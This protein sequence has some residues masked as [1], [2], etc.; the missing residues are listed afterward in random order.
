MYVPGIVVVTRK[1]QMEGLVARYGTRGQAKFMLAQAALHEAERNPQAKTR[2]GVSEALDFSVAQR[3]DEKYQHTVEQL[4]RDLDLGVPVHVID[5]GF[6]PN[7]DFAGVQ[8]VVVVGQDGLVANAAKYVGDA[9]IVAVNPDPERFDGIL[10]PFQVSQARSAVRRVLDCK[11]RIRTVT[12][13]QVELNDGQRMLAFNDFFVGAAS[14]ISARYTLRIGGRDEP[15]SSSGVLV[16]TG[17]GS[18]GWFSSVFNMAAG[19][20]QWLGGES[21]SAMRLDWEDRRLLW[22]VREPFVSKHSRADL[23]AG[24]LPEGQTLVLESMMPDAGV[25]FS[26]GI[27]SDFLQFTSGTIARIGV[28]KQSAR[29][30]VG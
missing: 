11:A 2:K 22:A 19:V 1:T 14:H 21:R 12:L 8:T 3:V 26:D 6:L 20:S 15:Q 23:V 10:L 13:A 16:S 4:E 28:A 27:E 9:P 25:I 24:V 18:T 17:A 30:V 7:Y 5:R 29:L